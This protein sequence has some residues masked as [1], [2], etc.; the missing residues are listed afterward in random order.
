MPNRHQFNQYF[1]KELEKLNDN[2]RDA[3]TTI[4]GPVLVIA[5]PGT[6]KTHI[7]ASRIGRILMETDTQAH[8]ILC[9]TFTD[10]G[11][12]AMRSRLL[13]LIGPEAHRVHIFTFHSFCNNIIR[14]NWEQFGVQ[15][16]ELLSDLERI[17]MVQQILEKLPYEHPL[18]RGKS[19]IY[20]FNKHL[21]DLFKRMKTED[22]SVALL[23]EKID[24][25]LAQLPE[26]E[27]F[28]YKVNRKTY[29]K[30]DP[31]TKEIAEETVR[32]ERL[33]AAVA[34]YPSYLKAMRDM[35]RYDYDDMILWVLRAFEENENLLRN[36]QEQYLY[37]LI[38]E[39][40]DTN[41][42]Q[43]HVLKKLM[44][45]WE[46]PNIFIV[47]DDDQA[48]YEFQGAQLKSLIDFYE[49][50]EQDLKLVVLKENYRS[51]QHILEASRAVISENKRRVIHNL[52]QLG[53][54]K[55]LI[56][57][58]AKVAASEI[59]PKVIEFPNRLHEITAIVQQIEALQKANFPLNQIAIIY[60]KHKQAKSL[61]TL[62]DKK[63]IPYYTKRRV[64]ILETP[65]IKQVLTLL[66]YIQRERFEPYSGEEFLFELLH[67]PFFNIKAR[68]LARM[69]L[70][71]R[72]QRD[73]HWRELI[74]DVSFLENL[75]N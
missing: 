4:E 52:Q 64:N 15:E 73:Q 45:F 46:N 41:G 17:E 2:Q 63:A 59:V 71:L 42:A 9:L 67:Y 8:N 31:K 5:G 66:N 10:A 50:Y 53:V 39:Y 75:K 62:L 27:E 22:W 68:D 3:V 21:Q 25:Y 58:N 56:A 57:A 38:D 14:R 29:R 33:R 69:S 60:A 24:S 19:D 51:S 35:L 40:Q 18:I 44:S 30:G 11:V 1:L 48:I 36:Y 72:G 43:N 20:Y 37:L 47:G 70:T 54:D 6:G 16:M 28:K 55:H 12:T 32:M 34:L 65:L 23:N 26:R 61:V 49:Q 13:Q 74:G 7:L